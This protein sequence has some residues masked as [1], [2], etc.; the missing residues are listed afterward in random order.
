MYVFYSL[1]DLRVLAQV[2]SELRQRTVPM[3]DRI[4]LLLGH[5]RKCLLVAARLEHGVPAKVF[6]P[7]RR[8]DRALYL[9]SFRVSDSMY[10]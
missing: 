7:A 5:F 2:R 4:L 6:R 3:R 1:K 10:Q 8:H 9:K